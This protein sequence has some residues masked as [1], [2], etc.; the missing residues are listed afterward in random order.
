MPPAMRSGGTSGRGVG[1]AAV[2]AD[3]DGLELAA[4]GTADS[5]A[6]GSGTL[7]FASESG[8]FGTDASASS[9]GLASGTVVF[10]SA[11]SSWQ[12]AV[13]SA[14]TGGSVFPDVYWGP[15]AT[16]N[17]ADA[18]TATIGADEEEAAGAM[19]LGSV[20][21]GSAPLP[22]GWSLQSRTTPVSSR[23]TKLANPRAPGR[24]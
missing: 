8:A 10:A 17:G 23:S 4:L 18:S 19:P 22:T 9:G 24:R 13:V 16:S 12:P 5:T 11:G 14:R 3:G 21:F 7:E 2:P 6:D 1:A 15:A 20:E